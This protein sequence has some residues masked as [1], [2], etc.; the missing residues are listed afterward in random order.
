M[1]PEGPCEEEQGGALL[2]PRPPLTEMP[3]FATSLGC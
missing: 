2:I 3:S 1:T